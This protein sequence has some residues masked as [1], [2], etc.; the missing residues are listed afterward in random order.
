MQAEPQLSLNLSPDLSRQFARIK[1]QGAFRS[2][3]DVLRA[4]LD[5]LEH[6]YHHGR[7][8]YT[9]ASK[10]DVSRKPYMS[11]PGLSLDDYDT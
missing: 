7:F 8:R 1:S 5:A 6:D 10:N 4:A 11:Q 2:D 3:Q 9:E